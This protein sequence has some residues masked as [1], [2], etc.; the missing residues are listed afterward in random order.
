MFGVIIL[1]AIDSAFLPQALS[2][3]PQAPPWNKKVATRKDLQI[4]IM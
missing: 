4:H 3:P 1:L 2:P